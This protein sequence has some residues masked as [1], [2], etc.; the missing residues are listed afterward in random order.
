M[1]DNLKSFLDFVD[2]RLPRD[3]LEMKSFG[4]LEQF[5]L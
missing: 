1:L 5:D 2:D 3:L 4:L